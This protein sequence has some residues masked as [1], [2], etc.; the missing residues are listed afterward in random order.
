MSLIR[1]VQVHHLRLGSPLRGISGGPDW[2]KNNVAD[3]VR[4]AVRSVFEVA[5]SSRAQFIY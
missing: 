2:L 4:C 5:S 3:A 1:F